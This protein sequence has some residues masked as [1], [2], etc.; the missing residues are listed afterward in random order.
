MK[1][2]NYTGL[3][4]RR[5]DAAVREED[6]DRVLQREQR[7]NAVIVHTDD[8]QE[9]RKTREL[10]PIDD[11]FALDFSDCDTLNEWRGVIRE[12]LTERRRISAEEKMQRELLAMIIADSRIPVDRSL[13][14]DVASALCEDLLDSLETHGVSLETYLARTGMTE[15]SLRKSQEE[16]ALL[17]IRSEMVLREVADRE[18]LSVSPREL[19][20]ELTAMAEEEGED[21]AVYAEWFDDEEMESVSDELLLEKAM[22]FIIQHAVIEDT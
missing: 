10:Q 21:P 16:D 2:G 14:Q 3:H 17:A 13:V 18:H 9:I 8:G 11:D 20:D 1:L 12:M 6:I 15:K 4:V 5:P 7:R 19:A 22:D